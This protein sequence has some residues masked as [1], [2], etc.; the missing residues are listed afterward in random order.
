MDIKKIKKTRFP[1]KKHLKAVDRIKHQ[2][3]PKL[4]RVL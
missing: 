2:V 4:L 3:L 1:V